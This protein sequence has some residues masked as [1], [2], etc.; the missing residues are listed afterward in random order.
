[1][2]VTRS[3]FGQ[4][5]GR[6]VWQYTLESG[7]LTLCAISYGAT[8]TSL[9]VPDSRGKLADVVTGF[10]DLEG[11]VAGQA[12]FGATVGRVANRI[13]EGRCV[14]NG[15]RLAFATNDPPHHLHGGPGGFDSRVWESESV[16]AGGNASVRFRYHSADG[17]EGYPANVEA[18]VTYTLTPDAEFVVEMTATTD[19]PT[20]VN[21]AHHSYWNLG[22]HDSGSIL[23]HEL[24]LWAS[25]Y[26]PGNPVVPDG[27]V[28]PVASTPF[29][30]RK[31]KPVGRDVD[32]TGATPSGY[33]HNFVVDGAPRELRPVASLLEPRS[34]RHLELSANQPGVQ[35]Y[36][37]N[38]LDGSLAGKGATYTHRSAL[39]LE[40]QAFPNAVNVPDWLGQVRLTPGDTYEHVM[41]HR[42]SW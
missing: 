15:R 26:T 8:V 17:E 11:Y 31:A 29:D 33:D 19:G 21:M 28:L 37:G 35:L 10:D 12:Y 1:M 25:H 42:F 41:R 38:F 6:D 7:G 39:C 24:K 16:S 2:S 27:R 18:S 20:L 23:D 9:H 3:K 40:T 5:D 22:G 14:F 36:S 32:R 13:A 4:I 34:G 30:F